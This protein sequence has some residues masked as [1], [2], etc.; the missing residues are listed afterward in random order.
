MQ[1]MRRFGPTAAALCL[2]LS[3][4]AQGKASAPP[5]RLPAGTKVQTYASGL[6]F[7]VDMAWVPGSR[8]MFFTEKNTG[9]IRV[10]QG[11]KL[12]KTP[13]A[14]LEVDAQA[15]RGLLGI[16]LHPDFKTNGFLYVYYTN[17]SPLEHRVTRFK[18]ENNRCTAAKNIVTGLP[19][20]SA[21]HNG[22]QLEFLDGKLFVSTGEGHS[23]KEAQD[24]SS[25]LGKILRY[26]PDGSVPEDNPFG[27]AVWSYGH[28]NPF[29]LAVNV[30]T[31]RLYETENGPECDDEINL[32]EAGNN[33]GWGNPHECGSQGTGPNPVAALIRWTPTIVPTDP[34][35]YRGKLRA[36]SNSLYMGDFNTGRL[37]RLVMN[38]AGTRITEDR[39]VFDAGEGIVDVSKGPGGWLYFATPT[40][41]F[42]I[43]DN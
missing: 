4:L 30:K 5:P 14:S 17:A 22:G 35:W 24:T 27:N 28:R 41:I 3:V 38:D 43:V 26:N 36:L 19:T 6:D 9:Q 7:P 42:R 32:I 31:G 15:E 25:R 40:G 29:G 2:L 16:I 23:P 33:Y 37:H 12:L 18:V 20:A 1:S 21:Y 8:T 39:I 11:G 13:C 34:W 10:L